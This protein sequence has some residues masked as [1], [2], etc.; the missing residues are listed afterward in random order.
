MEQ[1]S[2]QRINQLHPLIRQAALDAYSE[3]VK[4]TPAGIHPFIKNTF[5]TFTEQTAKY[6]LGRTVVNPDGKSAAKPFGNIVTDA[7]AG[8]SY[9]NYGLA[10][11]FDIEFNGAEEWNVDANWMIVVNCFKKYG[12]TWGGDWGGF[13]DTP[14][15]ENKLGY[16]WQDLLVKYNNEDFTGINYINLQPMTDK[17]SILATFLPKVEGFIAYPKWDYKQWSWGYGTAAGFDK[18]NKPAGT[19]TKEKALIDALAHSKNDYNILSTK[20]TRPLTESN[21]ATLLSF[22]YNEGTG[23]AENLV[24]DINSNSSNLEHHFKEY[25]Y[26]GG[27]INTDLVDRR[28][29]EWNLWNS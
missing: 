19:I 23:N 15:L 17:W 1:L 14:H 18:N 12:F 10:L 2:I 29:K 22:S 27:K 21:W 9:H 6:A 4:A 13:K 24:S 26:A 20:I 28:N 8:Q 7:K 3:A 11:D 16:T 25:V 5:R